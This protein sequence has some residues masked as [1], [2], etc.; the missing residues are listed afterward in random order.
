M[1]AHARI[2]FEFVSARVWDFKITNVNVHVYMHLIYTCWGFFLNFFDN[3][4]AG[5]MHQRMR[6]RVYIYI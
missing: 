4:Y 2:S 3:V 1:R 5:N 6:A